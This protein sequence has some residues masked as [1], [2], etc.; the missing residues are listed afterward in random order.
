MTFKKRRGIRLTYIEQGYIAFTCW[1]YHAQPPPMQ[2]KIRRL[3]ASCG[4]EYADALFDVMVSQESIT[5]LTL[6]H[7]VSEMLLYNLRKKFYE[8]WDE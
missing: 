2:E 3:C 6:K 5:A 1:T 7:H 8:S 4:G